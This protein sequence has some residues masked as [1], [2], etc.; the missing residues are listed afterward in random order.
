MSVYEIWWWPKTGTHFAV[1]REANMPGSE[2]EKL[3]TDEH[4]EQFPIT[5]HKRIYPPLEPFE[6]I[7]LRYEPTVILPDEFLYHKAEAKCTKRCIY[8]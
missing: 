5:G 2:L 6:L 1:H 8:P 3:R 7:S 4:F